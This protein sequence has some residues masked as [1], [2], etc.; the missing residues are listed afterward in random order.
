MNFKTLGLITLA[1]CIFFF[2]SID[3]VNAT[4]KIGLPEVPTQ[5]ELAFLSSSKIPQKGLFKLY[6]KLATSSLNLHRIAIKILF[7]AAIG[8]YPYYTGSQR[9]VTI[10]FGL[11]TDFVSYYFVPFL[12]QVLLS[13]VLADGESIKAVFRTLNVFTIYPLVL[14]LVCGYFSNIVAI[15]IY[16]LG[17]SFFFLYLYYSSYGPT[18]DEKCDKVIEIDKAFLNFIFGIFSMYCVDILLVLLFKGLYS[19]AMRRVKNRALA[20]ITTADSTTVCFA[21]TENK[22]NKIK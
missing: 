13:N 8:T 19:N 3:Q 21:A 20:S 5:E 14:M 12:V 4:K 18:I 7:I 16:L 1:S 6:F 22:N 9:L 2:S 17:S 11:L 15:D 10:V